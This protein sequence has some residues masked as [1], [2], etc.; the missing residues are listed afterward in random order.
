M[1]LHG[2]FAQN[3]PFCRLSHRK[4][5]ITGLRSQVSLFFSIGL[6]LLNLLLV[7]LISFAI[8]RHVFKLTGFE[9][10]LSLFKFIFQ[11]FF[12]NGVLITRKQKTLPNLVKIG[13]F[14]LNQIVLGIVDY[15]DD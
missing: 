5:A 6:C 4:T 10:T 15:V 3:R 13:H 9:P 8:P 14:E 12:D 2:V 7:H 11:I 1:K